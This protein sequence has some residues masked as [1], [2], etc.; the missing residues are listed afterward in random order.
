M[1]LMV[2]RHVADCGDYVVLTNAKSVRVTGRKAE[3]I[4]YRKH[5]MFPGGLKEIPYK[6]MQEKKPDEVSNCSSAL[7]PRWR[8]PRYGFLNSTQNLRTFNY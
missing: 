6:V 2:R 4:V 1:K 3:Q 8:P 7:R 5:S